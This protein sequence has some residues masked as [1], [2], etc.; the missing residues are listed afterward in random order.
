MKNKITN[1][2]NLLVR[3]LLTYTNEGDLCL[4]MTSGSGS[5]AE[6]C[7]RTNRNFVCIESDLEMVKKS[8]ERIDRVLGKAGLFAC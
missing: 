8:Q 1:Q 4:D 6:A 2:L 5:F 7:I 3:L